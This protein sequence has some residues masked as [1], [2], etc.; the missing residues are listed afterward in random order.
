M[1]KLPEEED[2]KN[3]LC[4]LSLFSISSVNV[5]VFGMADVFPAA[6]SAKG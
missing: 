1:G 6:M 4:H 2:G 3:T 5:V